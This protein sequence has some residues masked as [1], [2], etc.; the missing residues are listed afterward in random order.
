MSSYPSITTN[1][2]HDCDLASNCTRLDVLVKLSSHAH[3]TVRAHAISNRTCPLSVLLRLV[4]DP[5]WVVRFDLAVTL[6]NNTN[7]TLDNFP[8]IKR[9]I[10]ELLR[11]DSDEDIRKLILRS[12]DCLTF[13]FDII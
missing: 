4:H 6:V 5:A 9:K 3:P 10:I 1:A 13:N 8:D 11:N 12:K 7:E 2:A